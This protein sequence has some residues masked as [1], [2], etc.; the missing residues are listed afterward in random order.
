MFLTA[1]LFSLSVSHAK[2]YETLYAWNN[3]ITP[4]IIICNDS[5]TNIEVLKNKS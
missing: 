1:V 4:N 3:N 2:S 5:K